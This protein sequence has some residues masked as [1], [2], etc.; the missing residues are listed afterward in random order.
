MKEVERTKEQL[1]DEL[2]QLRQQ[3][4]ELQ[5]SEAKHK[6]SEGRYRLLIDKAAEA[7]AVVQDGKIKFANPKFI[8]LTR[9]TIEELTSI[10]LTQIV[11]PDDQGKVVDFH[12]QGLKGETL[13]ETYTFRIIDKGGNIKWLE[14][15]VAS[16]TWDGRPAALVFDTDITKRKTL[17]ERFEKERQEFGLIVDAS[18]IIIFYKDKDGKIVRANRTFAEALGIPEE[19]FVGKTVFDFYSTEIAQTMTDDDREVIKSGQPKLNIIEKYESASGIRWVRTD[20]V[21]IVDRNGVIA[22]LIGF[23]QDITEWQKAAQGL[24]ESEAKYRDLAESI[25]DPFFAMD[26]NLTYTYWNKA[27]EELTGVAAKDALGKSIYDIF[28]DDESTRRAVSVYRRALATKEPQHFLNERSLDGR[29]YVFE[30][31]AYPTKGGL[32]VYVKDITERRKLE[33]ALVESEQYYRHIFD[34]A[35]FGIGF[36]SID[37]KIINFNKAMEAITGYPAEELS[38]VNLADTYVDKADR[39]VLLRELSRNR[40]VTDYPVQLKRKDGTPYDALLTIRL[41]T[42]GDKEFVQTICHDITERKRAE[43]SLRESEERYRSLVE[44]SPE[45]IFVASEGKHVFINSAGLKLFGAS[46]PDQIIG[47][48]IIE[49]IHPDYREIVADR[50]QKA[51]QTGIAPPAVEEKFL[52]LDGTE[53]DVEVRAAPLIYQGKPAMQAVVRDISERKMAEEALRLSEQNFRDSIEKSPLGIRIV[54]EDGETLYANQALLDI[55]GYDTLEELISVPTKQRYTQQSYAE[56]RKRVK[57]RKLGEYVPSNYEISIVRKDGQ[58]RDLSVSRGEVL[59]NG[60]RQFQVVYQDITERKQSEEKYQTIIHTAMDGFMLTD[61]QEHILDVNEAYCNLIGYSRDELI[62]MSIVDIEAMMSPQEI[63]ERFRKIKEIDHNRFETR[64]RRKDGKIID[65]EVSQNYIPTEGGRL[66]VF[67]RDITERKRVEAEMR[68]KDNAMASS[69][70]GILLLDL[71]GMVFYANQAYLDLWIYQNA[72]EA[73]GHNITEI[74]ADKTLARQLLTTVRAKGKWRGELHARL[75]DGKDIDIILSASMVR[76]EKGVPIAIMASTIDI[77]ELKKAE[78][79]MIASEERYRLL[80][81]NVRDVIWA[82]DMDL[83]F[84]YVS[85]SVKYLGGRTAE[86]VMCMSLGQLLTPSSQELAMKTF[87][88]ELLM[89]N[90]RPLDPTRSRTL[91]VEFLRPDGSILW[92]ELK[93]NFMRGPDGGPVGILGVMRDITE[94]RKAEDERRV[95]EQKAQLASR[96]ASVGEL[97]SGIAHEINNPLTGVIGYAELLMQE[98]LPEHVKNDLE[99]IHDGARRVADIVKGLL[100]FAR[101]TKPERVLVDINEILQVTLH[102]RAYELE[103]SNIKVTTKLA[104]DL[105]LTVADAGQLQQVFLNLLINAEMEMKLVHGKGKLTIKT[106]AA[107]NKIRIC[108]KDDGPGIA[109]ENLE[110]IF[111][112]FFTTREIGE[113]T[114]LGLS[115]CHGIITEHHGKIWAESQPGNGATFVVELPVIIEEKRRRQVKPVHKRQKTAKGKILVVDDEPV[116]RQLLN[117]ILTEEGHEVETTADGKDALN[118]I[119]KDGY[120][121]IMVDMKLP[122]TSGSELYESIQAIAGPLAQRVV[123]ITGDVMSADTEA[124]IVRTKV[125]CITKPFNVHHLKAE[126]RRLLTTSS[127]KPATKPKNQKPKSKAK[128]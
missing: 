79:S 95:L 35:P 63:T 66:F 127:P 101:Q 102:L 38:M 19:K 52:R 48:P 31:S 107:D 105:P 126:V 33:M 26:E 24:S 58:F 128:I 80:A 113:G 57:K 68:I 90:V 34:N 30:I 11:H 39:D 50:M 118:R 123:L 64:H 55:Y 87:A 15:N 76:D 1:I 109:A 51:V 81:E 6:K 85:P 119:R 116:V 121:L 93:M 22:G 20:K 65:V 32:C 21:P 71:D 114:G 125:P 82:T 14:R 8:E 9:Y 28:P 42:I 96:L 7:I 40:G 88:E 74:A 53:I 60:E 104:Q 59:W 91:E 67:L 56:H 73:I 97:A 29:D 122:G 106:K 49:F 43:E 17:E 111:D 16:I 5:A 47:K 72:K 75:R 110:K 44:L 2:E 61:M 62:N 108:F 36:A 115:I 98:D 23:A 84:T 94:R 37:G 70:G 3:I 13:P 18:P 86:E 100:K 10:A 12:D 83:R 92:A 46:S 41:A 27:S 54:N 120:S 89:A 112:P 117:Q 4:T 45:A 78:E 69:I 99:V 124:F 103:T 77:T 25:T